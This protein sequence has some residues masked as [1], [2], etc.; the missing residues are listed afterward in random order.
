MKFVR[1]NEPAPTPA[2]GLSVR[3]ISTE[4]A[5]DF[6]RIVAHGF[7]LVERT[8]DWLGWLV[9]RPTRH[10]SMSF[11]GDRPVGTGALF[12][13]NGTAYLDFGASDPE[14]RARGEQSVLLA[15]SIGEARRLGCTILVTATGEAVPG[16]PQHSYHNIMRAGFKETYLRQNW[17]LDRAERCAAG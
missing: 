4:H 7:D 8:Q 17:V 16:D 14:F 15:H 13:S 5:A 10:V 2:S 11:D 9:G 6:A 3:A 1:G 12:V